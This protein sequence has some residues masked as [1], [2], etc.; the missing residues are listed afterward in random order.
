MERQGAWLFRWRSYF[1]LVMLPLMLIALKDTGYIEGQY[2]RPARLAWEA[3]CVLV[4]FAGL[5]IRCM[6]I[7]FA[8]SGTSGR[9]RKRQMAEA[10]NTTGMYS[11]VRHP[12]YVGNF[13]IFLG[14]A[15]FI[16]VWW[17]VLLSVL[18]YWMY[19]ER[20][21]IAEEEF[22]RGEFGAPFVAWADRTPLIIPKFR[23]WKA[24]ERRFSLK[25]ILRAEYNAFLLIIVTMAILDVLG[26]AFTQGRWEIDRVWAIALVVGFATFLTLWILR[27]KTSVLNVK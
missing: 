22:L 8:H 6:A 25:K 11:L 9:N 27:N 15:L 23:N 24:P 4:S 18:A 21:I 14:M 3:F 2:G 26:V 10:L 13:F 7:G 12:L 1:P 20:I 16:E 19:Y 17:F 5:G